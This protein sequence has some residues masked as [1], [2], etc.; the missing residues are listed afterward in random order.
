MAY[1][2]FSV[3]GKDIK[4]ERA[5]LREIANQAAVLDVYDR[6]VG[7]TDVFYDLLDGTNDYSKGKID[8]TKTKA[9]QVL[10]IGETVLTDKVES[11]SGFKIGQEITIQDDTPTKETVHVTKADLIEDTIIDKTT[12]ETIVNSV[13]T[14]RANARPVVLS[15][16]WIITCVIN[17]GNA[18][19]FYISK[20]N[21][22][23]FNDL[24]QI[25]LSTSI[26][27]ATKN[28]RL[29]ALRVY[30]DAVL[31]YD[32][33]PNTVSNTNVNNAYSNSLQTSNNAVDSCSLAISQD[34]TKIT[35]SWSAKTSSYPDSFNIFARQGIIASDGSVAWESVEQL[36][37]QNYTGAD[38]KQ[39][40]VTYDK[41]NKPYVVYI[42]NTSNY[43]KLMGHYYTTSFGGL[44]NQVDSI[45]Y[46]NNGAYT[47]SSPQV[48]TQHYRANAGRMWCVWHG[49]DLTDLS[50]EN[51]RIKYSDDEGLTWNNSGV[52]NEKLTSGN[53][54]AQVNPTIAE[55]DSGEIYVGWEGKN[56]SSNSKYQST[57]IKN[58]NDIWG[59]IEYL[60]TNII[61]STNNLSMC[62]N[63]HNFE[64][65]IMIWQDY[66]NSRV[67]FYG[68]YTLTTL[69]PYLE[70]T[71]LTN[72]YKKNA[73]IYRSNV[74]LDTTAKTMK[75]GN[76]EDSTTYDY[77]SKT[78]FLAS[79][80]V[81][82][83]SAR[84]QKLSNGWIATLSQTANEVYVHLDKNG[85]VSKLV[86][87]AS[88]YTDMAMGS[89]GNVIYVL[90][91]ETQYTLTLKVIDTITGGIIQTL[92]L[93]GTNTGIWGSSIAFT[94][95]GTK[96]CVAYSVRESISYNMY[97]KVGAV[98]SDG[99]ITLGLVTKLSNYNN[100][101]YHFFQPTVVYNG[102]NN[103]VVI[104][105]A[106]ENSVRMI[107]YSL[108]NGTSWNDRNSIY[109]PGAYLQRAPQ[110][111]M[112]SSNVLH[113]TWHGVDSSES[114]ENIRYS[115][116]TDNGVSWSSMEKLTT[117]GNV[118][119]SYYPTIGL[120][121]DDNVVIAYEKSSSNMHL[122]E[123][124]NSAW[125]DYDL[126][127]IGRVPTMCD[128]FHNFEKPLIIYRDKDFTETDIYGKWTIGQNIPLLTSDVRYHI[129][130]STPTN[131]IVAWVEH[132]NDT[133]FNI[134][135]KISIGSN[136]EN[137]A[138]IDTVKNTTDTGI[139]SED[140]FVGVTGVKNN[141]INLKLTLTRTSTD[142][143][144]SVLQILGA[145]GE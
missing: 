42:Y 71:A 20:D 83:A 44:N 53:I 28:N 18:T 40:C 125:T 41:D 9:T 103:P 62:N 61:A 84:P 93:A 23:T 45:Y 105:S 74:I 116:S 98:D 11:T 96:V 119:Y 22:D 89:Q 35:A 102:L 95:D 82:V 122:L 59:N 60:T 37:N 94:R 126:G 136:E 13:Y 114:K 69:N 4:Q 144:K 85:I 5:Y 63:Y 117:T 39:P 113:V 120:D 15:N 141:N 133:G 52:N 65:P 67:A 78:Q 29:Y 57:M 134:D 145:I 92:D 50:I 97:V 38:Y 7:A 25:D 2:K 73:S 14:T 21:G 24:C 47:Q 143:D 137:E 115:K 81:V 72:S 107:L 123:Y 16:G 58:T 140:E 91:R 130:P 64:K 124:K 131:E 132:E 46:V 19:R 77:L 66:E 36:T 55:N 70:T 106:E 110:V 1:G 8:D 75:I 142:I 139:T 34:Q 118:F 26:S 6:T 100:S 3:S 10:N 127:F 86:S 12:P 30:S 56:V 128:N 43:H 88:S 17:S 49:R 33:D 121:K 54:Y 90:Y 87:F 111:I 68:K 80:N 109:S 104:Y 31:F 48:L 101:T 112:D 138:Y 79:P 135:A 76:F 27:I 108:W 99:T 51:I 129:T 32:I